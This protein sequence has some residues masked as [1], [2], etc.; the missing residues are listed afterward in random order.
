[1]T[2]CWLIQRK[3]NISRRAPR[4][5]EMS[6]SVMLDTGLRIG[7]LL[8]LR[9]EDIRFDPAGGRE[10]WVFEGERGARVRTRN[11][12]FLSHFSCVRCTLFTRRKQSVSAYAAI[13]RGLAGYADTGDEFLDHLHRR[14]CEPMVDGR[15]QIL[16][17]REFVLH[18]LRHTFSHAI[19]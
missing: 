5:C 12:P 14:V 8:N 1:M 6:A 13:S 16:F 2:L 7:E 4:C 18:G 19:G 15:K 9:W 11:G 17:S 3:R 10:V